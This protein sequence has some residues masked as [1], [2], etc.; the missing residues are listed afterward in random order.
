[1]IRFR[2]LLLPFF[3]LLMSCAFL[4]APLR[5]EEEPVIVD[6]EVR[7]LEDPLKTNVLHYLK[8]EKMKDDDRLNPRWIKRLHQQAPEEIRAALQPYGYYLP[9]IKSQLTQEGNTWQAVYTVDPGRPVRIVKR[10][11]QWTGPGADEPVFRRSIADYLAEA[12]DT[13]VHADYEATKSS[14]L[15]LALSNGYPRAK[16]VK[17]EVVVDLDTNT[18]DMTL[19][20]DTGP[21][22]YFGT[23][24]FEQNFL[25]PDLL[26]KYVTLKEGDPYSQEELLNFQQNLIASNYAR[27]IILE[28]QYDQ[29]RDDRLPIK[30]KMKPIIPHRFVFGLGFE[31]DIGPRVSARWKDRLVNRYGHR[32][33]VYLKLS[34]KDSR[35]RASYSVP[36][37]KPLTDRWVSIADYAYE[38]TPTT[39]SNTMDVET[40]FVRR[41]LENTHFYKGFLQ[42]SRERF[43]VGNEPRQTTSLL[44]LGGIMRF[45]E[46]EDDLYPQNGYYIF[47]DLRGAAEAMLSDT[48]FTR[49]HT[50]GRYL[51]QLGEK[52][53]LDT[54]LE[55]G[56]TWV[57]DFGIYPASLRFFAGGDNSVRGYKYQSLGPV[58]ENQ[59]IVV[60]GKHVLTG[61]LEYDYRLAESWVLAGFVDAGNAYNDNPETLHVGSGFG[62]RWLAPFGSLRVDLAWPVSDQ[63]GLS[64]VRLHVGFG[65]T[66]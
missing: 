13:L 37:L 22:Y 62:V 30:V 50:K 43:T 11:I 48:S 29:A 53:R 28:P 51:L 39:I 44:T 24:T 2:P 9:E 61:S 10:D 6:V 20:L 59:G 33:D 18:A 32:S 58:D 25:D 17:S 38:E 57:D 16:I 63:S 42:A 66:L 31:S 40:A 8:I 54:R 65:A 36:V 14:F 41:N 21:R 47:V 45:S 19:L 3:F 4:P 46:I 64:D 1:M 15:N 55:V 23:I 34:Q 5:A 60:G 27:E 26:Q 7:G 52:G 12:P 49:L 56:T 35:F